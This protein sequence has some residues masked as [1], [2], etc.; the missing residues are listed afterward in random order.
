MYQDPDYTACVATSTEMMLNFIASSGT[1]MTWHAS[2][3][4][5]T[6]EKI[7]TWDRA[8]DT[9]AATAKGTDPHGFR[10]GLNYFGWGSYTDLPTAVYQ[11][12]AYT[13]YD[14]AVKAA[15]RAMAR[16]DKPVGI[17]GWGGSHAQFLN[18]YIVTGQDPAI[19]TSFTVDYVYLTDPLQSD[20]LRNAKLSNASFKGGATKYRF[21]PYTWKDSPYDDPYGAGNVASY[22]EWYGKWVIVAPVR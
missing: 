2:T 21:R 14:A 15:V 17:L 6:E 1:K 3:L 22:K 10:N 7:A 12:L 8:H 20:G 5:K 11:D 13:S 16:Y 18:G 19:S 9:I 4:Y